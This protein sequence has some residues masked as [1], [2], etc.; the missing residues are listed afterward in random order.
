MGDTMKSALDRIANNH[1]HA[2]AELREGLAA[3]DRVNGAKML[4]KIQPVRDI[5]DAE[6][7]DSLETEEQRL[8][9]EYP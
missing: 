7:E 3:L 4:R 6:F 2:R 9:E 8:L 1:R 5:A